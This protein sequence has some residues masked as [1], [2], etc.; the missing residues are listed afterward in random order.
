MATYRHNFSR[1]VFVLAALMLL[2]ACGAR[3]QAGPSTTFTPASETALL[4]GGGIQDSSRLF[5]GCHCPYF[6]LV[7]EETQKPLGSSVAFHSHG[8]NPSAF[9]VPAGSYA[10]YS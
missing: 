6:A 1:V 5:S 9:V 7:D 10:M 4:I 3:N 2:S 8:D